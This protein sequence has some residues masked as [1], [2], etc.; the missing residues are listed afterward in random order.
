[1]RSV[2]VGN[3]KC[4]QL[5]SVRLDQELGKVSV[6]QVDGGSCMMSL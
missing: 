6:Q 1:M 2:N 5:L 4:Q 3:E